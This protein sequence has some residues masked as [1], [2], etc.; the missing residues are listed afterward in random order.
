MTDIDP[1]VEAAV[2]AWDHHWGDRYGDEAL[3]EMGEEVAVALAAADAADRA[4]GF[5]RVRVDDETVE[6]VARI[7]WDDAMSED[8]T[9]EW[10]DMAWNDMGGSYMIL[11]GTVLAALRGES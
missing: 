2:E 6:R 7:L 4:A 3:D 8:T 9:P 1:R 11:A 5:V 10:R